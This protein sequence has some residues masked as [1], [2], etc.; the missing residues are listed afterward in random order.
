MSEEE[1]NGKGEERR[2]ENGKMGHQE[3]ETGVVERKRGRKRKDKEVINPTVELLSILEF[4]LFLEN[5]HRLLDIMDF[6][7]HLPASMNIIIHIIRK[8]LHLFLCVPYLYFKLHLGHKE[9][10]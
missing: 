5:K 7:L 2:R 9:T 1:G 3:G 6:S 4:N 10:Q 8:A